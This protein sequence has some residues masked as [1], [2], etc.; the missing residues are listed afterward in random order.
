M[1]V[2]R[3]YDLSNRGTEQGTPLPQVVVVTQ[4]L[5]HCFLWQILVPSLQKFNMLVVIYKQACLIPREPA[6]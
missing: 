1:Q 4:E 6:C 5:P 3:Y 2:Q